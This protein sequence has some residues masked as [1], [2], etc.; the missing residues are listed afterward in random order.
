MKNKEVRARIMPGSIHKYIAVHSARGLGLQQDT[1]FMHLYI[2]FVQIN[3]KRTSEQ[4]LFVQVCVYYPP[5]Q[6]CIVFL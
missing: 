2:E 4:L 6:H 3:Q 1:L 5:P